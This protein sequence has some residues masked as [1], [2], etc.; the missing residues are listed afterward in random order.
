MKDRATQFWVIVASKD[1]VKSAVDQSIAQTCHGK[2]TP[3]K[4]MHKGDFVMFYSGKQT[5][6]KTEKCQ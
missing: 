2:S 3:L 5:L 6:G 1:H 4:R